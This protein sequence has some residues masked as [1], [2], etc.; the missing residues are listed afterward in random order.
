MI[1]NKVL[2]SDMAGLLSSSV[3]AVDIR[4]F[5]A[6]CGEKREQMLGCTAPPGQHHKDRCGKWAMPGKQFGHM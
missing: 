6:E 1:A 3:T 2:T 5:N 4:H